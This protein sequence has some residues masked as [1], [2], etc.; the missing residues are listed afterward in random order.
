M[1]T[2]FLDTSALVKLYRREAGSVRLEALARGRSTD[3]VFVVSILAEVEVASAVQ[4]AVEV[5]R[6]PGL[7]SYD[8][9]KLASALET[10]LKE[11][12]RE[13]VF[14]SADREQL[15]AA[16]AEGLQY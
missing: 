8:A 11:K 2:Y 7:R 12:G 5:V 6:A 3:D 14:V 15:S 10:A 9:V 4:R 16:Q 13:V 1:L